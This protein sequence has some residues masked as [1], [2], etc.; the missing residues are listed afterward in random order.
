MNI[1]VQG[2]QI[3]LT[4]NQLKEIQRALDKRPITERIKTWKDV[5]NY[6]NITNDVL[7]YKNPRNKQEISINRF[8]KLQYLVDCLNEGE[9]PSFKNNSYK[10]YPYF[11]GSDRVS[12]YCSYFYSSSFAGFGL[13]Y[14]SKELSDYAGKQFLEIYNEFLP[15]V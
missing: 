5:C 11:F 12:F 1:Q 4:D 14:K 6:H 3:T 15:E 9:K 2:V 10:Y 13:Y 7:P 8:A